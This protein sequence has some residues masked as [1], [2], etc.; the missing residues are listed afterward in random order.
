MSLG[1]LHFDNPVFTASGTYGF[2]AEFRRFVDF[3]KIG[4][5]VVKSLAVFANAGNPGPR[6]FPL[7]AGMLNSVGLPG[8]G[9]E[10]WKR[11][12]FPRLLAEKA[13]VAVSIWGRTVDDYALAAN[14]LADVEA[15]L[16]YLELNI[17]CPNLEAGKMLFAHDPLAAQAVVKEVKRHLEIPVM[18]KLSPNTDRIGEVAGAVLAS[19]AYG[20][21]AINT[22]MAN[23]FEKNK[24]VL[25]T[26]GGG[27]LSGN[28]IGPT[29][30]RVVQELREKFPQTPIIGV[31]GVATGQDVFRMLSAGA[32]A[33]QIGTANFVD[34][35]RPQL[36]VMELAKLVRGAGY[37]SLERA[38]EAG[39]GAYG[40]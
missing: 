17:S 33:V 14:A 39:R 23:W 40:G 2:G 26:T 20:L 1:E 31:G 27:G 28:A 29:A 18:V 35:R 16:K 3:S 15:D 6:L 25:G 22:V 30:L 12:H 21:V 32:N 38:L 9:I 5:Q 4:C 8:P 13:T 34:P 10:F 24:P 37:E 19:G 7:P 11:H 36:A